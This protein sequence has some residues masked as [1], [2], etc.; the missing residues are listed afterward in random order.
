M[1]EWAGLP[2]A[3]RK[4]GR[5]L[6]WGL[7]AAVLCVLAPATARAAAIEADTG[8]LSP[9]M[10]DNKPVNVKV[11]LFLTNL[12]DVDEVKE[13]F[14]ISGYLFMTWKDPRL[15]FSPAGGATER[16]YN[17][18]SVWVPRVLMINA[19]A[20]REKITI[21]VRGDPDG[22]IHYL[23]LFQAQLTTS[24]HLEA[25]PFDTE[26]MGI[27]VQPFLDERDTMTLQY[28]TQVSGVGSEPFVELAQWKILGVQGSDQTH[29]IGLTGKKISEL[30]IDV[31]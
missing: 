5:L 17:P 6:T 14:H 7:V 13:L 23:E 24:F 22:T 2:Q 29:V 10:V 19:T 18:D 9:P 12:I 26:S 1:N 11:G 15:A 3:V 25:F 4:L 30:E 16:S 31:V 8:L 27:F 28:E 21:N 20:R